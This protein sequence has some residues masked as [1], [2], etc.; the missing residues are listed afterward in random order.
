MYESTGLDEKRPLK[1]TS[2]N[3]SPA[4]DLNPE[5]PELKSVTPLTARRS[6][7]LVLFDAQLKYESATVLEA[8][9]LLII[10][11]FGKSPKPLSSQ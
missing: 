1:K 9:F 8:C 5:P 4:R 6:V 11:S 3:N 7:S 2:S 10:Q